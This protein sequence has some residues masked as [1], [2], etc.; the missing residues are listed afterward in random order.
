MNGEKDPVRSA[1]RPLQNRRWDGGG[2]QLELERRLLEMHKHESVAGF[3][4]RSKSTLLLILVLILG[5]IATAT[6]PLWWEAF[7]VIEE[8]LGGGD[9]RYIILD[10]SGK[11]DFDEVLHEGDGLMQTDDGEYIIVVDEPMES[12]ED[13]AEIERILHEIENEEK[14]KQD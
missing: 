4:L 6:S 10:E 8:D 11:V 1:L 7:T 5:G 3:R 2:H 14:E 9:T 12:N 13:R